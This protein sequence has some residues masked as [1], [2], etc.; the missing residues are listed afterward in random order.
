MTAPPCPS[1]EALARDPNLCAVCGHWC[2][3]KCDR[4]FE[5]NPRFVAYCVIVHRAW[6]FDGVLRR[7]R[8]EKPDN[9]RMT[10]FVVW[11]RAQ[12]NEWRRL[13]DRPDRFDEPLDHV[14]FDMWLRKKMESA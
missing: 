3:L 8:E 11:L 9:H 10:A 12:V 7:L 2:G 1:A 14:A 13:S 6:D 4:A 5:W